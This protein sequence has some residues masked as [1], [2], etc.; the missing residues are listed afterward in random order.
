MRSY[1]TFSPLLRWLGAVIFCDTLCLLFD[2]PKRSPS[3]RW[4]GCSML[5]GLSSLP[6]NRYRDR[7]VGNLWAKI[8]SNDEYFNDECPIQSLP[9][10]GLFFEMNKQCFENQL[11]Y[12][13]NCSNIFRLQ[14]SKKLNTFGKNTFRK[15]CKFPTC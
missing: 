10:K 1:R 6:K 7:L 2:F 8:V 11:H 14:F 15:R 4:C 9:L 13:T 12:N 3:V 5:S